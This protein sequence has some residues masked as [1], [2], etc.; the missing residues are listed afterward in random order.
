MRAEGR[1]VERAHHGGSYRATT[2]ERVDVTDDRTAQELAALDA[3]VVAA[4][5]SAELVDMVGPIIL[6]NGM[7]ANRYHGWW[8]VTSDRDG[9]EPIG[10][11]LAATIDEC[12]RW[13]ATVGPHPVHNG[14]F[15]TFRKGFWWLTRD[16]EGVDP[17][18]RRAGFSL[19]ECRRWA[20]E[21]TP[22]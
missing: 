11:Y 15:A 7:W 18:G 22:E 1:G 10:R 5:A 16:R 9:K 20:E 17:V 6:A 12:R 3:D 21:L 2:G 8:R 14:M 4:L 19:E 13:A